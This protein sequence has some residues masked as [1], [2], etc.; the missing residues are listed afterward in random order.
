[1]ENIECDKLTVWMIRYAHTTESRYLPSYLQRILYALFYLYKSQSQRSPISTRIFLYK[2]KFD[3]YYYNVYE[4]K[5]IN[6]FTESLRV[7]GLCFDYRCWFVTNK[8]LNSDYFI[9]HVPYR[10]SILA[11]SMLKSRFLR[12]FF[13]A[14]S[15]WIFMKTQPDF[16][17]PLVFHL[18]NLHSSQNT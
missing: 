17:T 7:I 6:A 5:N 15:S 3:H 11:K 4:S 2:T 16:Q 14:S 12:I 9:H 8:N 13:A 1:M 18:C 10:D